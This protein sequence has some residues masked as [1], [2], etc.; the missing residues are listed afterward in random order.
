MDTDRMHFS[1]LWLPLLLL[2]WLP[3]QSSS[4]SVFLNYSSV[5]QEDMLNC[6]NIKYPFTV[7]GHPNFVEGFEVDCSTQ[8]QIPVEE[9]YVRVYMSAIGLGCG[10]G[11][12]ISSAGGSSLLNLEGT[13]YTFSHTRNKFAVIGCDGMALVKDP[14]GSGNYTTGCISFCISKRNI[15]FENCSGVGCCQSSIPEGLQKVSVDFFS[16]K[17]LTTHHIGKM[18]G[19]CNEAFLMD[20]D[21]PITAADIINGGT[22]RPVVLDWA[23]GNRTCE[24]ESSSRLL[25]SEHSQCYNS[26]TGVGYRCNC[27]TGYA[28]NPYETNGCKDFLFSDGFAD[29]DECSDPKKNNCRWECVN[30]PGNYQCRCPPGNHG[31]GTWEGSDCLADDKRDTYVEIVLGVVLS[32]L[33]TLLTGGVWIYFSL[34][35]RKHAKLK[36]KYFL[37]NGGLLLQH[38]I[39]SREF[40]ARIFTIEELERATENFNETNV[41][42]RGGYGTVY[43]GTLSDEEVVAIKKS[44]FVDQSQIEQFI[45]EVVIVSK[46]NHRNVVKLLG[47]CLETQVPLLVYEFISNG[48]LFQHLHEKSNSPRMTWETRLRIAV[49]TAGALAYLHCKA[50]VPIIHRDV[51]SANIL[52]DDNYTAKV[53]DFGA[54]RL[55]PLNQTHITT[56]VEGTIGY[57]D[58]QY[59][60]TSQL[61]QKSD[62]YSFGVVLLELLTSEKPISFCKTETERNLASHFLAYA[63]ERP[64]IDFMDH[65]LVEEAGALQLLAVAEVTR[66]CLN[67]KGEERP[68][69]KEV[70][71]ELNALRR[72]MMQKALE[73]EPRFVTSSDGGHSH[74]C[75][76]GAIQNLSR[77][78]IDP[79]IIGGSSN[80]R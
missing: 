79:R 57:L 56:L 52:L 3:K 49:E 50:S 28:G 16:I 74:E 7:R 12:T 78:R 30:R 41:V 58:P 31:N 76:K 14:R 66:R 68:T 15:A 43:K 75:L 54:S 6:N 8:T 11:G 44:K 10:R 63:E 21:Y 5:L 40:I 4:S 70:V 61:T 1:S 17:N 2:L 65:K 48:T 45:N 37:Q 32:L 62:V 67:L 47:C 25:C 51:K 35:N 13:P 59:F 24:Q 46:I 33:V 34:E 22:M 18:N 64:L 55:V 42:G 72:L 39:S 77:A 36:R 26:S 19:D 23:I 27:S 69:M 29:I 9:G 60:H 38:H 53:S 73:E 71:V 20:Q 80:G